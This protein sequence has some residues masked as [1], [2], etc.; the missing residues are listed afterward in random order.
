[1]IQSVTSIAEQIEGVEKVEKVW[2]RKSGIH[3]HVDMHIHVHP[4]LSIRT[5]HSLAGKVKAILK[6]QNPKLRHILIHVEPSES[7]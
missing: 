4:E 6:Q 1:M 5:A 7:D 3:Y 2:V